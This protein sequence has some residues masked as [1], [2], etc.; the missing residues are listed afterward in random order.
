MPRAKQ[1]KP[2][3]SDRSLY[4]WLSAA[5]G[6]W[7]GLFWPVEM[8]LPWGT[9]VY[10]L[11]AWVLV[12]T[13]LSVAIMTVHRH[14]TDLRT[15]AGVLITLGCAGVV[16]NF[17]MH[18]TG[19]ATRGWLLQGLF[20]TCIAAMLMGGP[21][22]AIRFLGAWSL[23]AIG[24]WVLRPWYRK[25]PPFGPFECRSCRFDQ[26]GLPE[27]VLCPECGKPWNPPVKRPPWNPSRTLLRMC[28]VIVA[29]AFAT[30][31]CIWTPALVLAWTYRGLS[32]QER[33]LSDVA[34]AGGIGE[35]RTT[36]YLITDASGR[37]VYLTIIRDMEWRPDKLGVFRPVESA[38]HAQSPGDYPNRLSGTPIVR[39]TG[40]VPRSVVL[41]AL[42]AQPL[43][44]P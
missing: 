43:P 2:P 9:S 44:P 35:I 8:L 7:C 37:Q 12:A 28:Q 32:M 26:T 25:F 39:V 16:G 11:L 1:P 38:L 36:S 40:L 10:V 15:L 24:S 41:D 13:A 42:N 30:F 23:I 19:I 34:L 27:H 29:F 21:V 14:A 17:G 33:I 31:A 3:V 22:I 20:T 6:V 18:T 5:L 4:L